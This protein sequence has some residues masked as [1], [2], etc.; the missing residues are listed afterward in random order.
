MREAIDHKDV[1]RVEMGRKRRKLSENADK[2]KRSGPQGLVCPS[3]RKVKYDY[4]YCMYCRGVG[5]KNRRF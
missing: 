3:A 2:Y 4:S 1:F 5:R